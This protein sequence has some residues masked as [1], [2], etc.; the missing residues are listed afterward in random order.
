MSRIK[1]QMGSVNPK[2]AVAVVVLIGTLWAVFPSGGSEKDSKKSDGSAEA[3][4]SIVTEAASANSTAGAESTAMANGASSATETSG[5]SSGAPMR[6][7]LPMTRQAGKP[8]EPLNAT[9]VA[10]MVSI[11]PFMTTAVEVANRGFDSRSDV[12]NAEPPEEV[13]R[14]ILQGKA[15]GAHVSLVYSSNRGTSATVINRQIL[16]PGMITSDGLEVQEVGDNG[17]RVRL[18]AETQST[19]E[20]RPDQKS[21]NAESAP[22]PPATDSS[23]Q[24]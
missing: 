19:A 1:F 4:Q 9:D 11:N 7:S 24:D 17:V 2:Q 23:G 5:S 13:Q 14:R 6:S 10:D 8:Y 15:A 3:D 20:H 22:V 18:Q 12:N 21:Q 16:K